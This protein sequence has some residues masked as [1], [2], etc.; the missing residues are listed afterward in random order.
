MFAKYL[1]YDLK[2]YLLRGVQLYFRRIIVK[3]KTAKSLQDWP[4]SE[5]SAK[6]PLNWQG[7]PDGKKFAFV[8]TH[9]VESLVGLK[10]CRD[11]SDID[12]KYGFKSLFNFVPYKYI[13]PANFRR[14]LEGKSFEIGIHD[15][16]HDGKLYRSKKIFDKRASKINETIRQWNACGFRSAAMHHNLEWIANLDISYDC[17]TFDTDPFEPQPDGVNT[18]FPF[19]YQQ[20]GSDR[21]FVEIPYT[22]PQDFT[23]FILQR[24]R[25]C[26]V[27]KE[28]LRWIVEKGGMATVIVHPDYINFDKSRKNKQ[29]EYSSEIYEDFLMHIKT[30]YDGKYW[31]PLPKEMASFICEQFGKNQD[32]ISQ[33]ELFHV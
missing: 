33:L 2:P 12:I 28:K 14:Y 19:W 6:L 32:K 5:Q 8:L 22:L 31:N 7:W 15:Y 30:E 18:I 10:K 24:E 13:V 23:L 25:D 29:E 27:W 20:K 11:L 17:S 16:N 1:Y 26:R 4:I 3:L 21:G 9:D